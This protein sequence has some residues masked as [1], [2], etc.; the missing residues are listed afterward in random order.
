MPETSWL[1]SRR[2]V[3]AQGLHPAAV[4]VD[5]GR[6]AAIEPWEGVP[7]GAPAEELG[8]LVLMP[9]LVDTHVH[10]NDPG[11]GDWEG[12]ANATRAAA[13]GGVTTL[14]DMPLNSVPATTSRAGLEGKRQASAGR[15]WVDL[16]LWGG[17]VPGNAGEL[18][19]LAAGGVRGF[20]AFLAPSG[21]EEFPHVAGGDLDAALPALARL[22]LPLLVHAE[23]PAQ[24][25]DW[26]A[27]DDRRSYGAYLATRPPAAEAA[28]VRLL[29]E[30]CARHSAAIHVVHVACAEAAAEIAAARQRGLP[31]SGETCPHYLTFAAEEIADGATAWKCAPPI[32]EASQ[33]EA[34]W[35]A[36]ADGTLSLVASDHSPCPP[37]L[38]RLEQ[39]DFAAAWGGIASLQLLLPAL[40]TEAQRRGHGVERLAEWLAASPARLAGLAS[41]KG[42]VAVG[43]DADLVAWD[44]EATFA[45][46]GA[47]LLHRHPVT[48]YEG[49][50]LQGVVR[51]TWLRGALTFADGMLTGPPRGEI[52]S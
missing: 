45:V 47:E 20:K 48:P 51:R 12:F 4:R 52:L 19:T 30:L 13:A 33:R 24:L 37:A 17:V 36:L 35:Q 26:Q 11:R 25:G 49:R 39:G 31:L 22:G 6:I 23:L 40:W 3:T 32:R 43:Y 1:R 42:A 27:G 50:R 46:R 18:A 16:G 15:L 2:V 21:V 41:R 44:P 28:A 7:A 8:D 34:L 9:G 38:K 10:C 5:G 29:A 14:V